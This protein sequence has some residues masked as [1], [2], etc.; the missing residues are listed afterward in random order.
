MFSAWF[1]GV[2]CRE[3]SKQGW[4]RKYWLFRKMEGLSVDPNPVLISGVSLLKSV[5]LSVSRSYQHVLWA[6]TQFWQQPQSFPG[7]QLAP[8]G[9]TAFQQN[10]HFLTACKRVANTPSCCW[11]RHVALGAITIYPQVK[12]CLSTKMWHSATWTQPLRTA[13]HER[14]SWIF[15]PS[16]LAPAPS[17]AAGLIHVQP[18]CEQMRMS[19]LHLPP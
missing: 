15:L 13:A 16:C 10:V 1:E 14:L 18:L 8:W 3:R 12:S 4:F 5:C 7:L 17:K 9:I 19:F 11:A 6:E 2:Y